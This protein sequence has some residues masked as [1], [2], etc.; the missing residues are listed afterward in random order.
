M[1]KLVVHFPS[2]RGN[3]AFVSKYFLVI[4]ALLRSHKFQ[5]TSNSRDHCGRRVFP[6]KR[7][8]AELKEKRKKMDW[9]AMAI[10]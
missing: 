4:L 7:E 2:Q 6:H 1:F 9:K 3:Q 5:V 8:L 10:W